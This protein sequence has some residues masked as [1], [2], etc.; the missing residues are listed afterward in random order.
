MLNVFNY[1]TFQT[2]ISDY[3]MYVRVKVPSSKHQASLCSFWKAVL[4]LQCLI[5]DNLNMSCI[6]EPKSR[7]KTPKVLLSPPPGAPGPCWPA[8]HSRRGCCSGRSWSVSARSA[9]LGHAARSTPPWKPTPR[10]A[11]PRGFPRLLPPS[12]G[13]SRLVQRPGRKQS[14]TSENNTSLFDMGHYVWRA[15]RL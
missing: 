13:P 1:G 2:A 14:R 4:Q 12:C 9:A 11:I 10:S 15:A 3:G 6:S 8:C 7:Q 5:I